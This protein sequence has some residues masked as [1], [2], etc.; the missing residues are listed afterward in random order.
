MKSALAELFIDYFVFCGDWLGFLYDFIDYYGMNL[1]VIILCLQFL[2]L[3]L[4]FTPFL[5]LFQSGETFCLDASFSLKH[6]CPRKELMWH[7]YSTWHPFRPCCIRGCDGDPASTEAFWC[8]GSHMESARGE[9]WERW[10]GKL[11]QRGCKTFVWRVRM[12][13][14]SRGRLLL[15]IISLS[16]R[17]SNDLL[18]LMSAIEKL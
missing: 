6:C 1:C 10:G 2:R 9:K 16:S 7:K 13:E 11:C 17:F 15:C 5:H 14:G 18:I 3:S 4:L 12:D 8:R